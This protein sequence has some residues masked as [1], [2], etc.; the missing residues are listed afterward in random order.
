MVDI[1]FPVQREFNAKALTPE[2]VAKT[3]VPPTRAFE[4]IINKNNCIVIGPRG[5]GKTTLFKML[6]REA[7][8]TWSSSV[9]EGYSAGIRFHSVFVAADRAWGAQLAAADAGS[10]A[11]LGATRGEAAFVIHTIIALISSMREMRDRQTLPLALSDLNITLPPSAESELAALICATLD[12]TA[13]VTSLLGVELGLRSALMRLDPRA[14][15]EN[16]PSWADM[17]RLG[18]T[19]SAIITA[20]D[21]IVKP[22]TRNWVFLFDELEIAPHAIKKMLISN[23]R[24]FDH[25]ISLKLALVPFMN[26]L[27]NIEEF[28]SLQPGNDFEMVSLTYPHKQDAGDFSLDF[29]LSLLS[30]FGIDRAT[31][32]ALFGAS[33]FQVGRTRMSAYVR[34]KSTDPVEILFQKLASKDD[35]FKDYLQ[36]RGVGRRGQTLTEEERAAHIR[37]VLPSVVA[38]DFYLREFRHLKNGRSAVSLRPRKTNAL[39]TGFP[40]ILELAEGNPRLLLSLLVPMLREFAIVRESNAKAAI[41]GDVQG[42]AIVRAQQTFIALIKTLP[43]SWPAADNPRGL[44]PFIDQ[45][46]RALENRLYRQPFEADYI[47]SFSLPSHAPE[48]LETAVGDALNAGAIISLSDSPADNTLTS[49]RGR[50]FRLSY[51]LAPRFRLPLT[52]GQDISLSSILPG[53][54]RNSSGRGSVNQGSFD[55]DSLSDN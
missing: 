55:L 52:T 7:L 3:F 12:I 49:L 43:P 40:S 34:T 29:A 44:L 33:I 2:E 21:G 25:R 10:R 38:R 24:G 47:G 32:P 16:W 48:T 23:L 1:E 18:H 50:V 8:A 53:R 35:S 28:K 19:I 45:I 13:P 36:R 30:S 54:P 42:R 22:K 31:I 20:F 17:N 6:T 9:L 5:S 46:G 37:K 41:P 11:Q 4:R 39:Y 26:D 15:L 27:R 51:L 14:G